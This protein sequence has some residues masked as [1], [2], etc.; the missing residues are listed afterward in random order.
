MARLQ[1]SRAKRGAPAALRTPPKD[2]S[3]RDL[4]TLFIADV[5]GKDVRGTM[6]V[7]LFRL[8]KR[9]TRASGIITY[10]LPDGTVQVTGGPM[11]MATAWDFDIVLLAISQLTEA[12]NRWRA[13]KGPKPSRTIRPHASEVLSFCR[14][15]GGG[16]QYQWIRE[17]LRRLGTTTITVD[18]K[19]KSGRLEMEAEPL[20]SRVGV[21]SGEST[22]RIGALEFD[23]PVW[24][25]REVVEC[26][27]PGVLTVHEDYF[28]IQS[29]IGRFLYRLFRRAAGRTSASWSFALL[30]ERSGS[31]G[32]QKE[33]NRTLRGLIAEDELPEYTLKEAAGQD[34]PILVATYRGC[35]EAAGRGG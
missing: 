7:A 34:G 6:D 1:A 8:S 11:G 28:L 14:R 33:F 10:R 2:D 26:E 20:L 19:S 21:F 22:D 25:Y 32:T 12:A 4:F 18:R 29:G 9:V 31:S 27:K 5:A 23:V 30:F 24:I 3:Q 16:D 35:S 17:A 15:S 13:G